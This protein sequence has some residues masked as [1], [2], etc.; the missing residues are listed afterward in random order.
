MKKNMKIIEIF[1][2]EKERK[3]S[4]IIKEMKEKKGILL[5]CILCSAIKGDIRITKKRTRRERHCL[6]CGLCFFKK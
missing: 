6:D 1:D 4:E 5:K 2:K 3:N